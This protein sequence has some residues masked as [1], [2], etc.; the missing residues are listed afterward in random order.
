MDAT[1]RKRPHGETL[2]QVYQFARQNYPDIMLMADCATE[3]E[4]LYAEKLGFDI[5]ATTLRGA[6]AE[7]KGMS[8]AANDFEFPRI[9]AQKLSIPLIVEGG[10]SSPSDAS[11]ALD[12]AHAVVVGSAMTRPYLIAKKFLSAL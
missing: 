10:V 9:M 3:E 4:I 1:C 7:S 2:K 11:K 6:T 12:G 5:V 8:N